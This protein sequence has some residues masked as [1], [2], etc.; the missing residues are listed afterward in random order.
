MI[1]PPLRQFEDAAPAPGELIAALQQATQEAAAWPD[2]SLEA[3]L[4]RLEDER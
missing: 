1:D 4:D 3:L 2:F